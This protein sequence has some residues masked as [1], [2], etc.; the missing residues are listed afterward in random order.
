MMK[1]KLVRGAVFLGQ[2]KGGI[3]KATGT[4]SDLYQDLNLLYVV[5]SLESFLEVIEE[6]PYLAPK[7]EDIDQYLADLNKKYKFNDETA[8]RDT[9]QGYITRA[10]SKVKD[11]KLRRKSLKTKEL[12]ELNGLIN[13][14][15]D[16]CILLSGD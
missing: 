2:I 13:T 8:G 15:I 14:W 11:I 6:I 12:I 7:F 4:N 16:R 3:D 5:D 1:G 10:R 9:Y